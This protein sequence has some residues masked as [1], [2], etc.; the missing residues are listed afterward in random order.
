[1]TVAGMMLGCVLL[2]QIPDLVSPPPATNGP[3]ALQPHTAW[4][5]APATPPASPA[6]AAAR[7]PRRPP[8][9]VDEALRLPADSGL[10]G[11]P[12]TL[13]DALGSTADRRRQM[14]IAWAY[15][16]LAE[17]AAEYHY[18]LDYARG[19][20]PA[21]LGGDDAG[22]RSERAAAAALLQDANLRAVRAQFELAALVQNPTD[23][24]L[25]LPADQPH[26]GAYR[27]YFNELFAGSTP[28]ESVRLADKL[29]PFERRAID[30]QAAAVLAAEDA[31]QAVADDHRAGRTAAADVASCGRDLLQQRRTFIRLVC[32]YNQDIA[33]YGLSVLGPEAN[34]RQLV[35]TLIGPARQAAPRT[36][37]TRGMVGAPAGGQ[38][39]LAPPRAKNEPTLAPPRTKNEPT[40]APP[41]DG[42][43]SNEPTLAPPRAKN[44]PT[45]A[46]PRESIKRLGYDEPTPASPHETSTPPGRNEP[47]PAPPRKKPQGKPKTPDERL[48][49]VDP[50][51]ASHNPPERIAKKPSQ[52]LGSPE[53]IRGAGATP[54]AA[55]ALYPALQSATPA[56]RAKQLAI[57]TN[58]DR[59]LPKDAGKPLDLKECLQRD[60]GSDRF[61]TIR[62]YWTLRRRAAQY[63]ILAEQ[64]E[65]LDALV[66]VVLERR[67]D[68]TG[69]A[70]MLR[71]NAA[72]LAAKASLAAART[73]LVQT[74]FDLALRLGATGEQPW[75]L[76][77]TV[78]HAGEYLLKLE[79]QPPSLTATWPVRRLAATMPGQCENVWQYAS[80]VVEAEKSRVA[81]AE[82]Y[83]TRGALIDR[84]L[85]T[86]AAQTDQTAAFLDS[87]LNYNLSIAEYALTILPAST[88][89][90]KL[91]SALVVKP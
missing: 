84:V 18:A 10:T 62:A 57:A 32:D 19:L 2:S 51:A 60:S 64:A 90:D 13:L 1:M 41:R 56:E 86:V 17:T 31:L 72:Q 49:P 91:V 48:T 36:A 89:A 30:E 59:S 28:P 50:Q 16:R 42:W 20:E 45:L 82:G 61:G 25:P 12:L 33:D 35:A 76:A 75:P 46:P 21:K 68:P 87:L 73:T 71:L 47:T 88:P 38:P 34:A 8:E 4:D 6:A 44:E 39:T 54:T 11:R 67:N 3:A 58:W 81:A 37:D 55:T 14:E 22:L 7:T 15:W 85:D 5:A 53:V 65:F 80:A 29:L 69:A 83:R 70:D 79:A 78:P 63:Q 27:T 23:A 43:Q 66:P 26:V 24:P 74:Q 9:L 52:P 77:S 40:L